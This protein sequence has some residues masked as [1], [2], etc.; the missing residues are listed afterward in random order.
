VGGEEEEGGG[1]H[2]TPDAA[3]AAAAERGEKVNPADSLPARLLRSCRL[4]LLIMLT[5]SSTLVAPVL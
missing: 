1:C 3:A 5:S 4:E 2:G